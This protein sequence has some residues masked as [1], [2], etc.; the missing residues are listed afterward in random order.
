MIQT[1]DQNL[2]RKMNTSIVLDTLRRMAPLSRAELSNHT[3]L[4]RSTISSIIQVLIDHQLVRETE[5]QGDRVGRPGMLLTLNPQGGFVVGLEI[6]VN[7]VAGILIDFNGDVHQQIQVANELKENRDQILQKAIRIV[8]ELFERVFQIGGVI[9]GIGVGLPGV[10]DIHQG[11]LVFAPNLGWRNLPIQKILSEQFNT[12]VFIEN[13]A[14]CAALGEYRYGVAREITD[15]IYLSA[16]VGLGGGIMMNGELFRGS[17][18]Y[19]GE[20]GHTV[21]YQGGNLCGCGRRG[22][23]ETYVGSDAVFKKVKEIIIS[24]KPSIINSMVSGDLNKLAFD[25]VVEAAIR[26]DEVAIIALQEVA[27]HLGVGITNLVNILNPSMIVLGGELSRI[28]DWIIS[29]ISETV[30]SQ[31]ITDMVDSLPIKTSQLGADAC[32]KGAVSLVLD[33]IIRNPIEWLS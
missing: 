4:N 22:C 31:A 5:L 13:E 16:G 30:R 28:G 18:G 1:A 11:K 20:I 7:Y 12:Q 33:E 17:Q 26:N 23:W 15:F 21:I 14:N 29:D 10:V 2:V 3:G 6:N 19:A 25:H 8:Q 32:L 24:G 9:F 27:R